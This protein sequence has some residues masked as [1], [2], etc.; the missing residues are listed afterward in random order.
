M[1]R[2]RLAWSGSCDTS[3]YLYSVEWLLM[4]C[5]YQGLGVGLEFSERRLV[6]IAGLLLLLICEGAYSEVIGVT[7]RLCFSFPDY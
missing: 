2:I 7:C 6:S 1:R 4:F 3:N 5:R